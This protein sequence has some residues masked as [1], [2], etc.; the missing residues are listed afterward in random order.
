MRVLFLLLTA[1]LLSSCGRQMSGHQ[2]D[3]DTLRLKHASLLT[4]VRHDGYTEVAIR[5]PWHKGKLLHTYVLVPRD[6]D[7]P[8]AVSHETVIRVPVRRAAVFTTV[9]CA[10]LNTLGHAGDIKAVAELEYIKI[11]AIQEGVKAGRIA[12]CG[13]GMNPAVEK[14]IDQKPDI[15]MLSP[16]ENSGGYGK[17]EDIG[18]PLVECAEYMENSPLARAEWVKFY[19]LLFGEEQQADSLFAVVDSSYNTLKQQARQAGRGLSLLIDRMV[20]QVWYVPGGRSTIGQMAQDA[21]A[22]YPWGDDENSGSLTLPFETVLERAGDCQAWMYRYSSDH[23]QTLRELLAEH[24]GYDQLR[25]FREQNVYGCNV[26]QTLFYEETPFRPD[27]LLSDFIQIVHP[28]SMAV[29]PLR[30]YK[31]VRP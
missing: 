18:I 12:D 21:G 6:G 10:L 22:R 5:N 20:G 31:K 29:A 23:E 17:L 8:Q 25:A 26:E 27:Y 24:R 7:V 4:I 13:N 2:E 3:G 19:G 16:F 11:P 30:Y 1:V 15:I 9:H 28:D 14:I